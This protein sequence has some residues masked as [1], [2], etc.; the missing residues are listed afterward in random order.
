MRYSNFYPELAY[1]IKIVVEG[2][3]GVEYTLT[4]ETGK[5]PYKF[6]TPLSVDWADE[7]Q[8]IN[9]KYEGFK[10]WVADPNNKF[11]QE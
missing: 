4:A 3:D 7:R 8:D 5:V 2:K 9:N 6:T 10:G 11:W 1:N